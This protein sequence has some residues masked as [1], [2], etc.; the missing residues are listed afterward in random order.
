MSLKRHRESGA[1][2]PDNSAGLA[3]LETL[4]IFGLRANYMQTFRDLLHKEGMRAEQETFELPVTWNFARNIDLKLI[5]LKA[6]EKYENSEER[7]VLP[8]PANARLPLITVDLY[9]RLHSVASDRPSVREG[10][11]T[12]SHNLSRYAA[13]F[14]T[15]RVFNRLLRRKR[16]RGWHN[17]TIHR[18][19]RREA[20]AKRCVVRTELAARKIE[21]L[22]TRAGAGI[23][24]NRPRS[25]HRIR[26]PLLAP[27]TE[28]LG[29]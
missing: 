12:A 24:G 11:G 1:D 13:L 18:H 20:V 15:G 26:E 3:E 17:L 25:C 14:N 4:Y 8:D 6:N 16:Q 23:G 7:L 2:L 5:R 28:A 22:H 10:A 29:A 21:R 19:N 27:G 9:S